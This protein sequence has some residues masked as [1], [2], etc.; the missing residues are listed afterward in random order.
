MYSSNNNNNACS[1]YLFIQEDLE[2]HSRQ[3]PIRA[4]DCDVLVIGEN[5]G[6]W[7]PQHSAADT[8]M[9]TT[10]HCPCSKCL[11]CAVFGLI[12]VTIHLSVMISIFFISVHQLRMVVQVHHK[13]VH[14]SDY[15]FKRRYSSTAMHL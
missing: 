3:D 15:S 7:W 9:K 10:I 14:L 2:F 1:F 13:Y 12:L 6:G 8:G 11:L 4:T 5:M